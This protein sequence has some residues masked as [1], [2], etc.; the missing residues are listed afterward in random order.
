L[1]FAGDTTVREFG[2]SDTEEG[3]GVVVGRETQ[4]EEEGEGAVVGKEKNREE[5][6]CWP[7]LSESQECI[8]PGA[9]IRL[10]VGGGER[11]RGACARTKLGAGEGDFVETEICLRFFRYII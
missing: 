5:E 2:E 9:R 8:I 4:R 1:P 10:S 3:E 7:S 6:I 11:P